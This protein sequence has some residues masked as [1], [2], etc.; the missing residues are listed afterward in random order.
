[1]TAGVLE[2]NGVVGSHPAQSIMNGES[3]YTR[4]RPFVPFFLVPSSPS[5][6]F[7]GLGLAGRLCDQGNDLVPVPCLCQVE[8]HPGLAHAGEVGVAVDK[9]GGGCLTLEVDHPGRASDV[10]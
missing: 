7:P 5:D 2:H 8:D 6:P 9:T 10:R 4:F 3:V 1:M